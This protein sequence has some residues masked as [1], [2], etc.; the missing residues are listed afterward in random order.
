[1]LDRAIAFAI[2]ELDVGGGD[3]VLEI[4]EMLAVTADGLV[5]GHD[6]DRRRGRVFAARGIRRL[7]RIAREAGIARRRLARRMTLCQAIAEAEAAPTGAR[8]AFGLDRDAGHEGAD[9]LVPFE[10]AARLAE[11]MDR[12]RPTAGMEHEIAG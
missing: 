6:P 12:G 2:G 7:A 1:M 10:F 5:R 4:D 8:R 9:G 11:K 3:V